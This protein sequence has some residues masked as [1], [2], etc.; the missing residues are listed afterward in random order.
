[1]AK[2][3]FYIIL[4]IIFTFNLGYSQ[5]KREMRAVWIAHVNNIDFPSS[6]SLTENQQ[7]EQF[8]LILDDF[9]KNNINCIIVQ[10]RTNCDA[11][12]PSEL[13][14]WSAFWTGKQGVGPGYDP[15]AFMIHECHLRNMEFHAWFNPYR[16]AP[17]LSSFST[18]N[19][20]RKLHPEW[21]LAYNGLQMLDPGLPAVRDYVRMVVLDVVQKYDIDAVHFDDYFYPYPVTG[22]SLNDDATFAF[23]S[24]GFT[25]KADWRRD[26]I[27]LL[28]K[29]MYEKIHLTKPWVKFGI[30]PFG[31]WKNKSA[32]Q[33]E[34]SDSRGLESFHSIYADSRKWAQEGWVDYIAPQI[35]WSIG[36][37]IADFSILAPWWSENIGNKQRHLY[38]GHAAYRIN[39]GGTDPNWLLASQ[40]PKQLELIRKLP[41]IKGS[42]FYNTTTFRQNLLGF[43][44]SLFQNQYKHIA[45]VPTMPWIDSLPPLLP[46]Q[47]SVNPALNGIQ[48]SWT[49]TPDTEIETDK[50]K[51]Y[52]VYRFKNGENIDPNQSKNII[53]V[54]AH[55]NTMYLDQDVNNEPSIKYIYA[56]T[57]LDRLKNE[58]IPS[59]SFPVSIISSINLSE[60]NPIIGDPYPNPFSNDVN[61]TYHLNVKTQ[62]KI[63][64][65]DIQSRVVFSLPQAMH[66][67]GKNTLSIDGSDLR[68]GIYFLCLITN[69]QKIIKKIIKL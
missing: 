18:D 41:K 39:N 42:V 48:L 5:E 4:V 58:S 20:V 51:T 23:H 1:M 67:E 6:A 40:M 7:K 16:A 50:T 65:L 44:D 45:I 55:P 46:S 56:V 64:I 54:I 8:R 24:R 27:D 66:M 10:I 13:E 53:A 17:S 59:I 47:L 57:A 61:I 19:H 49:A 29:D 33:P 32:T 28:I 25:N 30:S 21:I 43:N 22:V 15:L 63:E 52:I 9:K 35:Y 31:I 11:S 2:R 60:Q 34:G 36:F 26:N 37:S 12:Y 3:F 68:S 14:P 69:N 62:V 38:I